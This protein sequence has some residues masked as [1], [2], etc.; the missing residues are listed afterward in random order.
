[1]KIV[2]FMTTSGNFGCGELQKDF[3]FVF[4]VEAFTVMCYVVD[5]LCSS[6][7]QQYRYLTVNVCL[8]FLENIFV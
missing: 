6:Y 8:N 1:M 7:R 4:S 2:S 3:C 5:L